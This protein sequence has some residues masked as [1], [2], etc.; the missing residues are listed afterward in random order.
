[1]FNLF[2]RK[3]KVKCIICKNYFCNG[4][5]KH[6]DNICLKC[7]DKIL[8]RTSTRFYTLSKEEENE[9]SYL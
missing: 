3:R 2:C 4:K 1:M 9:I 8:K 5:F 6:K 7:F